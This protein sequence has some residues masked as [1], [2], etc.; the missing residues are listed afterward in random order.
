[1]KRLISGLCALGMVLCVSGEAL[2]RPTG[3]T[4]LAK[5]ADY[6]QKAHDA[7]RGKLANPDTAEF[8]CDVSSSDMNIT[9]FVNAK[10]ADGKETGFKQFNVI[11]DAKGRVTE[12]AVYPAKVEPAL[13]NAFC[14]ASKK[15]MFE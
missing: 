8:K 5:R 6:V 7:I 10:G 14:G 3:K 13:M 11:F 15:G 2:A 1:M 12:C 9:G 4:P